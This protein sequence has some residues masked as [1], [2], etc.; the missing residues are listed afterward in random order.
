MRT[1]VIPD[2][3]SPSLPSFEFFE[4]QGLIPNGVVYHV[5]TSGIELDGDVSKYKLFDWLSP[6]VSQ[7]I[8]LNVVK[9][10]LCKEGEYQDP[11]YGFDTSTKKNVVAKDTYRL[12]SRTDAELAKLQKQAFDYFAQQKLTPDTSLIMTNLCTLNCKVPGAFMDQPEALELHQ[13]PRQYGVFYMNCIDPCH[14]EYNCWNPRFADGIDMVV[15]SPPNMYSDRLKVLYTMF[16]HPFGNREQFDR[17]MLDCASRK[18][19]LVITRI[20]Y[21]DQGNERWLYEF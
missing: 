16:G 20:H 14:L 3:P 10:S 6:H 19:A 2:G 21:D 1:Y 11:E 4:E 18:K 8:A 7:G 5:G 13:N 12:G 17:V 9:K 15:I